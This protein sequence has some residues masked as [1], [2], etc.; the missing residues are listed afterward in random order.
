MK[1]QMTLLHALESHTLSQRQWNGKEPPPTTTPVYK[2]QVTH[3]SAF[4]SWLFDSVTSAYT[5]RAYDIQTYTRIQY[6][7][8]G[9]GQRGVAA[10]Q[11][12][13]QW[14]Q[15]RFLWLVS[16][17]CVTAT[18]KF[19]YG[20]QGH[21]GKFSWSMFVYCSQRICLHM[22]HIFRVF[23]FMRQQQQQQQHYALNRRLLT[24]LQ[25][26]HPKDSTIIYFFND[27]PFGTELVC[28]YIK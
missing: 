18:E 2:L 16:C 4:N 14:G 3:L 23:S 7:P 19:V 27:L 28:S 10:E 6:V 26:S 12:Q 1:L 13:V 21:A 22:L 9:I 8:T 11:A 17:W 20:V 15:I 24:E 5:H 25:K